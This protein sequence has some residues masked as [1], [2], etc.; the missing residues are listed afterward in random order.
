MIFSRPTPNK[1]VLSNQPVSTNND[2]LEKLAKACKDKAYK[3]KILLQTQKNAPQDRL[4]TVASDIKSP[5]LQIQE[6]K[7]K[8]VM[9]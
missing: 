9:L 1:K 6:L 3:L 5:E 8:I 2:A 7:E 4:F